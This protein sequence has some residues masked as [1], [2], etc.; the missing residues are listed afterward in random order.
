VLARYAGTYQFSDGP[1][2]FTLQGNHLMVGS[3]KKNPIFAMSE[4]RFFSKAWD[5]Q[6]E[7]SKNNKGEFALVTEHFNGE[8][9]KGTR[10]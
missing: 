8:D 10:K 9:A 2:V 5:I 4:T 3:E 6:F 1:E 7:F